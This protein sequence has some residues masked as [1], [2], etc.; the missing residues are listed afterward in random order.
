MKCTILGI[1]GV[2][3]EHGGFETFAECLCHFLIVDGW[4]VTVYCQENG[5]G[6]IYESNWN[7]IKR[8]HIP[9]KKTGP[10]GA[11]FF[12]FKSIIHSLS[13]QGI[14][15]TLGYNTAIFNIFH[16][17]TGKKNIINMD[18]IEWHRQ[19]WG[20]IAKTWF[21]LNERFGCWFGNHLVAD[22]P[23]IADHLAARVPR[24]KITM[25]PYG[26]PEVLNADESILSTYGLTKNNYAIV[27]ARAEP[28]NSIYEI[29]KAFSNSKRNAKLCILGSYD[30][31][32]N[33]YHKSI[34]DAA[35][36]EVVFVGAIY[37]SNIVSALRF[38]ATFYIHGHKV[39]GTNPSLVE[40]LGSGNAVLA[41]DN[42]FNRWV[43]KSGAMYFRDIGMADKLI[44]ELFSSEVKVNQ[45]KEA[46]KTN[47][48]E[49]FYWSHILKQYAEL[50]EKWHP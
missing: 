45:L 5:C 25:I 30:P 11:V 36:E 50:L 34:L 47:F 28:E 29:V 24:S 48:E 35:S 27:I 13:N 2:P 15:L 7:G 40:A 9:I 44:G 31:E 18:G 6:D 21:W 33:A 23:R 41:H 1:R 42:D 19:K 49:S 39:G 17:I 43:A 38:Y 32:V 3:A 26:A 37:D 10:I 4:D 16:R 12:D 20:V 22:H 8:I 14:F 46:S